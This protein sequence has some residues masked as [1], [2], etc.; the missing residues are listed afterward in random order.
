MLLSMLS[1]VLLYHLQFIRA[2]RT[3]PS[4]VINI[5]NA[6][7]LEM[8]NHIRLMIAFHI[9]ETQR[10]GYQIISAAEQLRPNIDARL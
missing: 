9:N 8:D 10:H 4:L 5:H 3:K 6:R 2:S 7:R 1:Q